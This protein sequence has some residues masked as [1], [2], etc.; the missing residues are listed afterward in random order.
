MH[1]VIVGGGTAGWMSAAYLERRL[2]SPQGQPVRITL[3]ESDD[4]P[5]IGVGEATIPS[6]VTMMRDLGVP[7]YRL[8]AEVD[9]TFKNAIKF[10][11][12]N[13]GDGRASDSEFYHQ[14]DVP[15]SAHGHS[16]I[17]HWMALRA[18]GIDVAPLSDATSIGSALCENNRAPKLFHSPPYEAPI[19]YAYHLDAAKLG[20]LLRSI[21]ESRG[22][23]RIAGHVQSAD[24]D[25][26]GNIVAVQLADGRDVEGDFFLD[27]TGFRGLL[28]EGVLGAKWDSFSDRLIC[29]TAVT[30]QRPHAESSRIL[31]PYTTC[32]AKDAGWVWEIDLQSRTGAGYVYSSRFTSDEQARERLID[33]LGL[34]GDSHQ[35]RKIE[36]RIGRR[37]ETW[38]KNCLAVGLSGGFLE[39]LES[40][41]IHLIELALRVFVDHVAM[42]TCE[43]IMRRHYNRLMR[44]A[45]DEVADFLIMHYNLNRRSGDAFWDFCREQLPMPSSLVEKLQ[46]WSVKAPSIS[47]LRSSI[48]VFSGFSYS[49]ILAGLGAIDGVAGNLSP[50]MDLK[51]SADVLDQILHDRSIA[52]Q[53]SP[54][55]EEIIQKLRG[56]AG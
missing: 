42:G 3:I 44:D 37:P 34:D 20:Q 19:P 43:D 30:C 47:D 38:V 25:E 56:T 24:R 18:A 21:A 41:G 33:H 15:P 11:G 53:A 39:P 29:D 49:T 4:I 12:W 55:H 17:V 5:P 14:F 10:V 50:F 9:A 48:N 31:R 22:V 36:M 54:P 27:C 1:F 46:L 51:K 6:I 13:R 2:S 26:D 28:I 52:V 23:Q 45:F 8:F 40:T 35:T 16:A 7:E 32:T